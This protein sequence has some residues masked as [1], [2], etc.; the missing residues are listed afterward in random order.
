MPIKH[1]LQIKKTFRQA[2]G[3][4]VALTLSLSGCA[5]PLQ[6]TL[7][8]SGTIRCF[9]EQN[10][11]E[12]KT[13]CELSAAVRVDNTVVFAND[14][15]IPGIGK[16]P[17]FS[18]SLSQQ[19]NNTAHPVYALDTKHISYFAEPAFNNASKLESLTVTPDGKW[20][21]AATGFDRY[22]PG[23]EGYNTLLAWPAE[24]WH[25][26]KTVISPSQGPDAKDSVSLRE[27]FKQVLGGSEYFKIEGLAAIPAKDGSGQG[28]LLFG[29]RET[30][31]DYKN[32]NHVIQIIQAGY[33]IS[34]D[35]RLQLHDD[36][37]LVADYTDQLK[38][39][40]PDK[41][42]LGLSSIEYDQYHDRLYLLTS[43]EEVNAEE[44]PPESLG[45]YLWTLPLA[46][47]GKTGSSPQ[48]IL[49]DP[50]SCQQPKTNGKPLESCPL[51]FKSHKAEG[52]AVLDS[53]QILVVFDDDRA[54]TQVQSE[55]GQQ[56]E[57]KPESESGYEIIEL[58]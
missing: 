27:K 52:L 17:V 20:V 48:P 54:K 45:A 24:D 40:H 35:K 33:H 3:L 44:P 55:D 16:S 51:E 53:K 29:V 12:G 23:Q 4:V 26:V 10:R 56:H 38:S 5:A 2:F 15:P 31:A 49:V 47:L 57:R 9:Q 39:A 36:F 14:K 21:V 34:G 7:K 41:H 28:R 1:H 50:A 43:Y 13:S 22:K 6:A 19:E 42:T 11:P 37:K 8:Q 25:A 58:Y 18:L 32:P 46:D 30:G